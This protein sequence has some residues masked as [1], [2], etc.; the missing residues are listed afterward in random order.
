M[1]T[2]EGL[3]MAQRWR[4]WRL[5]LLLALVA[6]LVMGGG[7]EAARLLR[8]QRGAVFEGEFWR[9]LSGH[10]AHLGWSHLLLNLAGLG[11]V[12]GICGNALSEGMWGALILLCALGVSL[13]LLL[14]NPLLQWYVGF[15]GVLHGM[16]VAGCL[17]G[18]TRG[19]HE[20]LLLFVLVA[21]KLGWEQWAGP[22][23][24]SEAGAGGQVVVD[25]HLYGALAGAAALIAL[26][27]RPAW[28]AP[29]RQ[30]GSDT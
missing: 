16:L 14:F 28:R 3:M 23:P 25:A 22:L 27:L 12:W 8:Y 24:G 10:L 19:E 13:G 2:A 17:A 5:P 30:E 7:E 4:H 20:R 29:L 1:Q 21:A 11:L 26:W 18:W 6:V 15:S 9:L